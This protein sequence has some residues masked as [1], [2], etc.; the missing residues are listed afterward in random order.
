MKRRELFTALLGKKREQKEQK[1][2]YPPYYKDV[3]D[4]EKCKECGAKPCVEACE[5]NIIVIFNNKPTLDFSESGCTFCDACADVCESGVLDSEYKS[6]IEPPKI[7]PLGCLAWQKTICSMCKD[8]CEVNAI[9][10]I[11][12]FNPEI[13]EKCIGCGF[14]IAVCPTKAMEWE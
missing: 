1:L 8:I 11:A 6:T 7:N 4:F 12:L 3:T 13:N 9:D 14:C 2:L 10:F 5:E